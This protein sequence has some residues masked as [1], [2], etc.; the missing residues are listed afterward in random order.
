MPANFKSQ[1]FK[2]QRAA[3]NSQTFKSNI[4]KTPSSFLKLIFQT[5]IHYLKEVTDIKKKKI[6]S[7]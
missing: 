1:T 6:A 3:W 2:E 5:Y 4:H 7:A